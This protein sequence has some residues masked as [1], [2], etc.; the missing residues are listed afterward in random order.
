VQYDDTPTGRTE[1]T[2]KRKLLTQA[3][4]EQDTEAEI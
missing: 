1:P 2:N 3:Q 4:A